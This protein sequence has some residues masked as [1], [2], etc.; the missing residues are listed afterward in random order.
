MQ[1]RCS[2]QNS[3]SIHVYIVPTAVCTPVLYT[4]IVTVQ[5][6]FLSDR[7]ERRIHPGDTGHHTHRHHTD[8]TQSQMLSSGSPTKNLVVSPS[9]WG[10][11]NGGTILSIL[12]KPLEEGKIVASFLYSLSFFIRGRKRLNGG[13][14]FQFWAS[15]IAVGNNIDYISLMF[16]FFWYLN[17]TVSSHFLNMC[18]LVSLF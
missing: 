6:S 1:R 16:C 17:N 2:C 7:L 4:L 15:P 9:W 8:T 13:V 10:R 3:C 11:V 18:V 5:L 14:D 12:Q